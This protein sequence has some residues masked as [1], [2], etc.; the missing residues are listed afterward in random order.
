MNI[1]KF[2]YQD[3]YLYK[4]LKGVVVDTIYNEI[5]KELFSPAGTIQVI[6][7]VPV[8]THAHAHAHA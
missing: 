4:S 8:G 7:P 5:K 6:F 2:L 1:Y 3:V